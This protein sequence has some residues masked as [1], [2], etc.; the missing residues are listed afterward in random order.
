MA[1]RMS[2]PT[3][4]VPELA[5]VAGALNRAAGNGAMPRTAMGLAALRAGQIL[6]STYL[7]IRAATGLR[8][9]GESEVR[10]AAVATWRDAP[11]FSDAERAALALAEA[12]FGATDAGERVPDALYAEAGRHFD[13]R[14]LATLMIGLGQV[15][16]WSAVALIGK[17]VP[18]APDAETWT[19]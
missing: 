12:V 6:T 11:Y 10:I 8:A 3:I 9:A 16:F 19:T 2:N 5:Q 17:P 7:T 14:T 18:G 13:D 4:L 15:A 1:S